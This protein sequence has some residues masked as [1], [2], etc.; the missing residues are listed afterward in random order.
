M[1]YVAMSLLDI[2]Q[3]TA[4]PNHRDI[5]LL[6]FIVALFTIAKNWNQPTDE[7]IMKTGIYT[8]VCIYM[9]VY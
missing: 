9:N 5:C 4:Y 8:C 1:T 2:Y 3:R 6:M 7:W